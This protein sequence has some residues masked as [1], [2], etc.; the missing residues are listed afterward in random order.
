MLSD[1]V[2]TGQPGGQREKAEGGGQ[3]WCSFN[4]RA[5]GEGSGGASG[6]WAPVI[7]IP[8]PIFP[9]APLVIVQLAAAQDIVKTELVRGGSCMGEGKVTVHWGWTRWMS[10]P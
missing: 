1:S 6:V 5:D 2:E 10:T 9:A 8:F 7:G 3:A 4:A